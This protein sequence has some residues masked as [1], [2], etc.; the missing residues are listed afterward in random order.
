MDRI[1]TIKKA[2]LE[3]ISKNKY[4]YEDEYHDLCYDLS[5]K[6]ASAI[7]DWVI[8]SFIPIKKNDVGR[9]YKTK[10][11]NIVKFP[12]LPNQKKIGPSLKAAV[13]ALDRLA[14]AFE[15]EISNVEDAV[16]RKK[17]DNPNADWSK[18][19]KLLSDAKRSFSVSKLREVWNYLGDLKSV[20]ANKFNVSV[21]FDNALFKA[22][23]AYS[24][25]EKSKGLEVFSSLEADKGMLF[26]F[27]KVNHVSFHMGSVSFPID[28]V[29]LTDTSLGLKVAKIVHN[30]QPGTDEIW[31]CPNVLH[32]LEIPGGSCKK[33]NIKLNDLC[34]LEE[35]DGKDR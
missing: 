27:E 35:D 2:I 10:V 8:Q 3:L 23:V 17:E 14:G 19:D 34:V 20:V 7:N 31:S 30:A 25:L 5:P 13:N 16:R 26:P 21:K 1:S 29:F 12:T 18:I 28:I 15:E 9:K 11:K 4:L 33:Y 24:N 6:E 32:V 22:C